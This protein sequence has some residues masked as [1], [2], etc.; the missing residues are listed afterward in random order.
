MPQVPTRSGAAGINPMTGPQEPRWDLHR[1]PNGDPFRV[2]I[3]DHLP[4]SHRHRFGYDIF[5]FQHVI[6]RAVERMRSDQRPVDA[7]HLREEVAREA[8]VELLDSELQVVTSLGVLTR[9]RSE[10]RKKYVPASIDYVIVGPVLS[11]A[12]AGLDD[13]EEQGR[14]ERPSPATEV[15]EGV[16]VVASLVVRQLTDV[17]DELRAVDGMG[18]VAVTFTRK[19]PAWIRIL[20]GEPVPDTCV[21]HELRAGDVFLPGEHCDFVREPLHEVFNRYRSDQPVT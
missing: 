5:F 21:T 18:Y 1:L 3:A 19:S 13:D 8:I 4:A 7:Q 15:D 10:R 6:K 17:P 9:P 20:G 11:A 12:W 14:R 2:R 16:P